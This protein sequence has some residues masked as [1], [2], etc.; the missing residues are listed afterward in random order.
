MADGKFESVEITDYLRP[1]IQGP[2]VIDGPGSPQATFPIS[3][4]A[5]KLLQQMSIK[6]DLRK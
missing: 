6:H 3:D 5:Q 4:Y 1:P 2:H